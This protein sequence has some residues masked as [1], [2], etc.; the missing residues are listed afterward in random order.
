MR[1]K[2]LVIKIS[3]IMI[4]IGLIVY[5]VAL[6][7]GDSGKMPEWIKT[8]FSGVVASAIVS[9]LLSIGEY[10]IAKRQTIESFV[11]ETRTILHQLRMDYLYDDVLVMDKDVKEIEE[12]IHSI[13]EQ[14]DEAFKT[15]S[16]RR[17]SDIYG[18]IDF[19]TRK[20]NKKIREELIYNQ[21]Y[22]RMKEVE[23]GLTELNFRLHDGRPGTIHTL[24]GFILD[25]QK[26]LYSTEN[27]NES[28]IVYRCFEYDMEICI[29]ELMSH[30]YREK[31]NKEQK[32]EWKEF[33][34]CYRYNRYTS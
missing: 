21:I 8:I 13:E 5:T 25:F 26:L 18:D 29:Q 2:K 3:C 6:S 34:Y 22:L 9:L 16:M 14:C 19:I 28:T 4:F 32:P 15:V 23:D 24:V 10:Q 11:T 12:I 17:L 31:I 33:A 7:V 20:S 30:I 1:A 27:R